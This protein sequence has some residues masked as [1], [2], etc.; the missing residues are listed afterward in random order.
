MKVKK[1]LSN[2]FL[3]LLPVF[4]WNILF[5]NYLPESYSPAVFEKDIPL[6]ISYSEI[7]LRIIVFAFPTVMIFSLKTKQQKI[8][9]SIYLIG[10]LIYFSSWSVI[11][12]AP[13][14]NWSKSMIGFTAPAFTTLVWFIG[15]ALIGDKSFLRIKHTSLIYILFSILFVVMHT[16][17]V[18]IVF[19][20][21]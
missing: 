6:L 21:L 3:L 7:F 1:Y 14:S 2:C 16:L 19:L 11:I 5:V 9:F 12:I 10:V 8:G 15:I 17:H 20:K 18:Y 13:E 4:L